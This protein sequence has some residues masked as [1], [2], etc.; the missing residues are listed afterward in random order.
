M[1]ELISIITTSYNYGNLI[2]ETIDS[3]LRQNY[4]NWELIIIDDGSS[5]N[6]I[7]VIK[8]YCTKDARIKLFC[9]KNYENQG[10]IKSMQLGLEKCNGDLVAFLESDDVLTPDSL[11]KRQRVFANNP[12]VQFLFNEIEPFGDKESIAEFD[13][14]NKIRME[15]INGAIFP[16]QITYWLLFDNIIPTFS[17]VMFRRAIG[18]EFDFNSPINA[19]VDLW[20]Y[21]NLSMRHEFHFLPEKL[22]RWRRHKK[23]Q[24][25]LPDANI[26]AKKNIFLKQRL[27]RLIEY[28]PSIKNRALVFFMGNQL[29]RKNLGKLL[30]R[31][32]INDFLGKTA[33]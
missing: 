19:W 28:N 26:K 30:H 29:L 14:Y 12:L 11:S 27:A 25:S 1:S 16:R 17:C 7:E 32:V 33:S 13:K 8:N 22:T 4:P 15:Y 10:L 6:S 9:H 21:F 23:S 5:D 31:L 20:I 3:V 24:T 18:D 2:G